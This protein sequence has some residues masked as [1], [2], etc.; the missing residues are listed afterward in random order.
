MVALL[1]PRAIGAQHRNPIL[2]ATWSLV[3]DTPTNLIPLRGTKAP[4]PSM[5]AFYG[6]LGHSLAEP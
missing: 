2:A 5:F 3:I 4:S 6:W 1:A